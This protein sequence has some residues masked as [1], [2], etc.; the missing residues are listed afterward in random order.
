MYIQAQFYYNALYKLFQNLTYIDLV[1][2]KTRQ[3]DSASSV[4]VKTISLSNYPSAQTQTP[5]LVRRGWSWA[6]AES[7]FLV[8]RIQI[9]YNTR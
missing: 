5:Y 3:Y 9:K 8:H 6:G 4:S 2:D 1:G 7:I